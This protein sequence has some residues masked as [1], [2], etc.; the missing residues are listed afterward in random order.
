MHRRIGQI[1]GVTTF[2][3]FIAL[4]V[5]VAA[6]FWNA[7][8]PRPERAMLLVL[9]YCLVMMAACA[10]LA[11]VLGRFGVPPLSGSAPEPPTGSPVGIPAGPHRPQPLVAHAVSAAESDA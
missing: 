8:D 3:I 10:L 9:S 7:G 2:A 1:L 5:L 11:F 6:S 4:S